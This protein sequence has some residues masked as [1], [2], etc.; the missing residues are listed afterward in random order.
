MNKLLTASWLHSFPGE[1][2]KGGGGESVRW[3]KFLFTILVHLVDGLANQI[4]KKLLNDLTGLNTDKHEGDIDVAIPRE[5]RRR[6]H[7]PHS[8]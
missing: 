7:V 8:G 2:K 3:S 6:L 1:K 4:P 5:Y